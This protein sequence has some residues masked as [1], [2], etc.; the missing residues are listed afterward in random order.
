[1][2][3]IRRTLTELSPTI[4]DRLNA[5]SF[6]SSIGFAQLWR[7]QGGR[8]IFWVTE[9]EGNVLA[10][11]PGVEFGIVPFRRFQ[12]MPDGCYAELVMLSED[13]DD[14]HRAVRS[15]WQAIMKAGY[16]RVH[17]TDYWGDFN[18]IENAD[19]TEGK[20]LLVAIPDS[21]WEP[22]DK[23]IRSEI[24]KAEREGIIPESLDVC[25][26]F[27]GFISL[28]RET[29]KRHNR[30]PRYNEKFFLAL[31]DL[32]TIDDR[33]QW[34]IVRHEGKPAASHINFLVRDTLL[35]WQVYFDK[36]FSFLKPNQY[37]LYAAAIGTVSEGV[38]YLNLGASPADAE[39]LITYK[40]KWG[41]EER[42]YSFYRW[43]SWLGR[44]L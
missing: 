32:A 12:S 22:P 7:N 24:R 40:R 39:D 4:I 14:R 15:T 38:R 26:H 29:E 2:R 30:K 31:A 10:V 27:D 19:V 41:G 1:M 9:E 13:A 34:V 28:M 18:G 11:L 35:N 44:L 37:M 17:L 42:R 3:T 5:A 6:F 23:K 25:E 20:T 43:A 36:S 8:E 21:S 33:L 16:F